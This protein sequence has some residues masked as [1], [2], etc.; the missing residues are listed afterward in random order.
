MNIILFI[1]IF[2]QAQHPESRRKCGVCKLA[3]P[4]KLPQFHPQ[5]N[6]FLYIRDLIINLN[7]ESQCFKLHLLDFSVESKEVIQPS[8]IFLRRTRAAASIFQVKDPIPKI[9]IHLLLVS[10]NELVQNSSNFP[11]VILHLT[12]HVVIPQVL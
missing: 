1:F 4:E 2:D 3:P 9:N 6:S 12:I 10:F 8:T 7:V 5:T 11:H